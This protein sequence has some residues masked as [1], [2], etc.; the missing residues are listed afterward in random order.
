MTPDSRIV[1]ASS[2]YSVVKKRNPLEETLPRMRWHDRWKTDFLLSRPPYR[3]K[4]T[5][6]ALQAFFSVFRPAPDFVNPRFIQDGDRL[7][8]RSIENLVIA[9]RGLTSQNYKDAQ[10]GLRR[11]PLFHAILEVIR[12]WDVES[13]NREL[14]LLQREP[15]NRTFAD[16]GALVPVVLAPYFRLIRLNLH[17]HLLPA[18]AKM[19]ELARM[20]LSTREEKDLLQRYYTIAREELALVFTQLPQSFYPVLLKLLCDRFQAP[21]TFFHDQE[22]AILGLLGLKEENLVRDLPEPPPAPRP[23]AAASPSPAAPPPVPR[24]AKRGFVLLDQ[25]FPRAGWET[26][27][28]TP[29][30]FGYFQ[31]VF[32]FPKGSDLIPVDD[33]IQVILPLSEVLQQLFFG[34]QNIQW[35]NAVTPAGEVVVLQE[36]LD[37]SIARWHFFVEEFFGK[38]YLPLL[39]EYCREV[40]R[41]GPVSPDARRREHQLLWFKRNYL[42]PHLSLPVMD[43]IRAKS[44]GYPNLAVQVREMLEL[45]APIA[46]EVEQKGAR[47]SLLLNPDARVRFPVTSMV[48]QRFQS[49]LRRSEIGD[50]GERKILDQG[51]NRALL[52]YTLTLLSSL[53]HLLS[54]PTSLLYSRSPKYL[55]RTSGLPGDDKPVYNAPKRNSLIL[56]KKLNEQPPPDVVTTP[57]QTQVGDLYGPLAA[58]EELKAQILDYH[59][60]KKP[61]VVVSFRVWSPSLAS[62]FPAFLEPLLDE[63]TPLHPLDDGTWFAL[64]KETVDEEGEDFVRKVLGA[65]AR[66]SPPLPLGALVIPFFT[67][68]TFERVMAMPAR[69]WEAAAEI[70]PQVLGV[71]VNITQSFEFRTD[72]PTVEVAEAEK[73]ENTEEPTSPPESLEP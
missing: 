15:R 11:I 1:P 13:L 8:A 35:G 50:L 23:G 52:F 29:D 72:V 73:T 32:E 25:L 7:Y 6:Q 16:I 24:I 19:Y 58:A 54:E 66:R 67:T 22:Q 64:M 49:A 17:V 56:L 61:F 40:E 60:T 14:A 57:W 18:L 45:L 53:D 46:V 44:L 34:F 47:S 63:G 12:G 48:S 51:N 55:Y 38:N 3:A 42:L 2:Q 4:T 20:Y 70:P 68:W 26:L 36:R 71:W 10:Q 65:A 62:E 59:N 5:G 9:V 69:G 43:D 21:D 39:Q 37:K 30:L 31:T 41:A 33:A 27:D 28:G